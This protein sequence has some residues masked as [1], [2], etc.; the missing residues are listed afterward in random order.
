MNNRER[1]DF[2]N[3]NITRIAR[4]IIAPKFRGIGLGVKLVRETMPLTGKRYVETLAVMARYNPFFEKA[5]MRRVEYQADP[6]YEKA[7]RRLEALGFNIELLGSKRHN[8]SVIEKLTHDQLGEVRKIILT[9]FYSPKFRSNVQLI[10]KVKE[11]DK[12]ALAKALTNRRLKPVYLIWENP[13][14]P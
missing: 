7:L 8:Q 3:R 6:D 2:I 4:V 1:L 11:L 13:L 10:E 12:E 14:K 9:Q 5:G